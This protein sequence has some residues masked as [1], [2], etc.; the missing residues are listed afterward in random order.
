[1]AANETAKKINDLLK[2]RARENNIPPPTPQPIIGKGKAKR[3]GDAEIGIAWYKWCQD[4]IQD[5]MAFQL[6]TRP[7]QIAKAADPNAKHKEQPE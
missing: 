1:M 3:R 2:S 6:E 7:E 4:I 5:S